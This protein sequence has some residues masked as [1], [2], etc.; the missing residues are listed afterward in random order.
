MAFLRP[1]VGG[2]PAQPPSTAPS[3]LV[4]EA[5]ALARDE[6]D[7][8]ELVARLRAG[9]L[10]PPPPG[11]GPELTTVADDEV[12][13]HLP[14]TADRPGRWLALTGLGADEEVTTPFGPVRTLVRPPGERLATVATVNDLHLGEDHC[15]EVAGTSVGPILRSEPGER[16]YPLVM[17]EAAVA[18]IAERRPDLVVAKGD[19]TDAGRPDEVAAFSSLYRSAFPDRLLAIAGNHDVAR[20]E[21]VVGPRMEERWVDGLGVAALDTTVPGEAGGRLAPSQLE[22]LDE[23][24]ARA[25]RPVLVVGHHPVLGPGGFGLDA[26]SVAGLLAVFARRRSILAYA[27]GHTHRNRIREAPGLAGVPLVEVAAVKDYP[28]SWAEYRVFEGG[29]L[30]IHRRIS[31]PGALRWSERC[32]ALV[33]GWYPTYALGRLEDRCRV[34]WPRSAS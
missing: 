5:N 32:R 3:V 14:A 17:N 33:G 25:D 16:P 23:L 24:A 8:A 15:G 7:Q 26:E 30:Q 9:R 28:G 12:V 2:S 21:T 13:W 1:L 19:L 27:A 4:S 31:A 22:W 18:E 29:V 20:G 10:P 6:L 34:L 11:G